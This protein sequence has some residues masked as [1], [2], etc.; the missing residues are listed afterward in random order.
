MIRIFFAILSL[1]LFSCQNKNVPASKDSALET[2][3]LPK[4]NKNNTPEK[5]VKSEEDSTVDYNKIYKVMEVDV[6]PDYVGGIQKFYAFLNKN[7]I[8]PKDPDNDDP[9]QGGIFVKFVIE[10]D[11]SVSNIEILRDIGY[12]TGKELERLLKICPHWIPAKKNGNPV[13]CLYSFPYYIQSTLYDV[14]H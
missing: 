8:M 14:N 11:G 13:R 1:A 5:T 12:G 9:L 4:K 3:E 7:Y 10:K 6:K 2:I